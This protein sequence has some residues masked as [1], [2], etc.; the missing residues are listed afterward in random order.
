MFVRANDKAR[1]SELCKNITGL[2]VVSKVETAESSP[3]L[4]SLS[5]T[6]AREGKLTHG[7]RVVYYRPFITVLRVGF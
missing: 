1:Y 3:S 4:E 6:T 7:F 2:A 5:M